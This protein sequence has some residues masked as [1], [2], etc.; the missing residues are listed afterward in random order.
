[1]KWQTLPYNA[2]D[3]IDFGAL[4]E[5]AEHVSAYALFPVF[6]LNDQRVA[7]LL[8]SDDQAVMWL[9]G[10]RLY[11]S[12]QSHAAVPDK[13]AVLVTLK[14]GWNTLLVRVANE[15]GDHELYLRL[16]ESAVDLARS[17]AGAK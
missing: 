12:M 5:H 2:E 1:M 7:I 4:T 8:G 17:R 3:I 16:S 9:N 10:E 13:D 14:T 6:S 15:T 11:E